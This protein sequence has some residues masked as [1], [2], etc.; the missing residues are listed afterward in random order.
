MGVSEVPQTAGVWEAWPG[1]RVLQCCVGREEAW[2]R[3][4]SYK[5]Q[6]RT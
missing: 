1:G 6:E 4:F 2:M 5:A 3:V